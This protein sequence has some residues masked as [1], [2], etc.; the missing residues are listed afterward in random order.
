M[1][2]AVFDVWL[3]VHSYYALDQQALTKKEDLCHIH[4]IH[5]EGS[6]FPIQHVPES[7]RFIGDAWELHPSID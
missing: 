7:N 5:L 3:G 2:Q 6:T 4:S 1:E